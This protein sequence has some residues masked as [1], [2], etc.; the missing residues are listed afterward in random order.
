MT[1]GSSLEN[2]GLSG[3]VGGFYGVRACFRV[4]QAP[5]Y[6]SLG[7]PR[8]WGE[9]CLGRFLE[10]LLSVG[11][12]LC[13]LLV[14]SLYILGDEVVDTQEGSRGDYFV[15]PAFLGGQ[16]FLNGQRW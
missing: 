14:C 10:R 13:A 11:V 6:C 9:R 2:V 15:V 16:T 1:S 8:Q 4:F 5:A 12:F 7:P 3:S